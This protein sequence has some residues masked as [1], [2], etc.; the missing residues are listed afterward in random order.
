MLIISYFIQIALLKVLIWYENKPIVISNLIANAAVYIIFTLA[1]LIEYIPKRFLKIENN[2]I[3]LI[4]ILTIESVL[5][6][7]L[8]KQKRI[9]NGIRFTRD[10]KIST[11]Y[12]DMIIINISAVIIFIYCLFIRSN[13]DYIKQV[14]FPFIILGFIMF[15][16][17]QKTLILY[18]KQKLL[19]KTLEEDKEEIANK[20]KKI[21][22][23]SDEKFKISKLNHEFYN[24]QKSLELAVEEFVK[25]SK[26]EA[27]DEIGI[28]DKIQ[29]LSKEYSGKVEEIKTADRLY[30]T[31]IP[32]I[33]DMFK[34]TQSECKNN[35]IDFNLQI[36]GNIFYMINNLIDKSRLVT[37]IGDHIRDAII[38][39]NH[40]DNK[41]RSIIAILGMKDKYYEFS[42]YDTGIEFEIDTLLKLGLEPATTHKDE[43]GT[44]IGFITTFETLKETKASLVIEEKHGVVDNDYTKS[45][46]IVFD[47]KNEYR[48]ISYRSDEIKKKNKNGRIIIK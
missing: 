40:S 42:V 35:N 25:N 43:G 10:N 17:I 15:I 31:N 28:M 7:L 19:K 11:D 9:R 47:G 18:Y 5:L 1:T 22:E 4:L 37:L 23:L 27:S 46:N 20:D 29:S 3:N 12:F 13:G 32:E 30:T 39:I 45:V 8:S 24:R 21:Q 41:N 34:Y 38:A 16:M 36:N 48:I 14:L 26:S 2:I 44:G 33:D 6:F